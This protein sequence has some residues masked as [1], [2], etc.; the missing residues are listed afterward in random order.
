MENIVY[1]CP[2]GC[3]SYRQTIEDIVEAGNKHKE[4]LIILKELAQDQKN[5]I[6]SLREERNNM[7][8]QVDQL[9][10]SSKEDNELILKMTHET[11]ALKVNIR[12]LKKEGN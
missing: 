8:E 1:E 3:H 5:K 9:E 7:L 10:L 2:K 6:S 12:D 11:R 4:Q